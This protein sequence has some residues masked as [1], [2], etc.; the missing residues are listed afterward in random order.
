M[1]VTTAMPVLNAKARARTRNI[2]FMAIPVE[3]EVARTGLRASVTAVTFWSFFD[4]TKK[5]KA[6]KVGGL[7]LSRSEGTQLR[8]FL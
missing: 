7:S 8:L 2:F 4:A 1:T 5:K 3:D 6:T